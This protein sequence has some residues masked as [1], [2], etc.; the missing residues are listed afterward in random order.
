MGPDHG[1]EMARI[2][3]HSLI[4]LL[5]KVDHFPLEHPSSPFL[6]INLEVVH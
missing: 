6:L 3:R 2:N 1:L 4:N 5:G